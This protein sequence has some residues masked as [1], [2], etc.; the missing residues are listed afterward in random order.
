MHGHQEV[1]IRETQG[2]GYSIDRLRRKGGVLRGE[3]TQ[4]LVLKRAGIYT[5]AYK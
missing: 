4:M 2:E 5:K 1:S 3:R